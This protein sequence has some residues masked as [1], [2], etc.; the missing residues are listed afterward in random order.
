MLIICHAVGTDS[1]Y[2]SSLCYFAISAEGKK[3]L[4]FQSLLPDYLWKLVCHLKITCLCNAL[5]LLF[6]D[7]MMLWQLHHYVNLI[8]VAVVLNIFYSAHY[9]KESVNQAIDLCGVLLR[10]H[11]AYC[12][13]RWARY[14]KKFSYCKILFVARKSILLQ[15]T[16]YFENMYLI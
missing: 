6:P 9:L 14:S 3:L 15:Y 16:R 4:Q 8:Y 10:F 2:F 13:E 11:K 7:L 1:V 12:I 5:M